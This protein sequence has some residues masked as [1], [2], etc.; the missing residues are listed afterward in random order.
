[1]IYVIYFPD[2]D[3]YYQKRHTGKSLTSNV[4]GCEHYSSER[5]AK[6]QAAALRVF[7]YRMGPNE[8]QRFTMRRVPCPK[9]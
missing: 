3:M 6:K 1:M 9:Q 2:A 8:V 7:P 4:Y 5:A